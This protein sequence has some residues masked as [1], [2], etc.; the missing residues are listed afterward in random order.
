VIPESAVPS[1]TSILQ[2][3]KPY[4]FTTLIARKRAVE[5]E[6]HRVLDLSLGSP[7]QPMPP[8]LVE[9][10]ARAAQDTKSHGYP[11]MIGEPAFHEAFNSFITRRFG[12]TFETPAEVVPTAGA[13]EAI[14]N[15]VAAYCEPGDAML[16]TD[17]AY[18]VYER[19]VLASG[20]DLVRL[21][22]TADNDYWPNLHAVDPDHARR[23][24]FLLLNFPNNPTG[25][26][27]TRERW[28][29]AVE[30]CRRNDIILISDI[31][32]SELVHDGPPA[33]SVFEVDGAREVAIEIHSGS[34]NFSMAGM[35]LGVVC[36]RRDVIAAL[37]SYRTLVGY[38]TP[39]IVQRAGAYAFANAEELSAGIRAGYRARFDAAVTG[40]AEAG[41]TVVP[42][43]A[44][45]YLWIPVP[46]GTSDWEVTERLLA[47]EHIVVTPGSGFGPGGAGYIRISM[48]AEP[49]VLRDASRRAAVAWTTP[50]AR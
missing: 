13:K 39:T 1:P 18:P 45:M 7:D 9:A 11:V 48:V 27:T 46:E 41:M 10:V 21:P 3:I 22:V 47:E 36:G 30:F 43:K 29:E 37:N 42:P 23:A 33:P 5:A 50:A 2:S 8:G 26:V 14:A 4:V 12:V 34:K 38:G 16:I 17:V 28:S 31:A 40:F 49:A 25:A 44:G 15:L 32:Y 19:A 24:K 6:G 35:R 20:A